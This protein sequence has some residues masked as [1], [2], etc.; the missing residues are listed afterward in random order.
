M[1]SNV[2][3]NTIDVVPAT[4]TAPARL[5]VPA[6]A[7]LQTLYEHRACPQLLRDVLGAWLSWQH[8]VDMTVG[9]VLL[10]PNLAPG[11]IAALLALDAR[12]VREQ[13]EDEKATLADFLRGRG[14]QGR[15]V[16]FLLTPLDRKDVRWAKAHVARMPGDQPMVMAAATMDMNGDVVRSARLALSGVWRENARLAEAAELL[17]GQMPD[18]EQIEAVARAVSQEVEPTGDFV[19]SATYRRAMAFI[20]TRRVLQE[21]Q[22]AGR[23]A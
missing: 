18:E 10:S 22:T 1:I 5:A 8:R 3:N 17:V 11:L 6:G 23:S 21:C 4:E 2:L 14:G 20:L 7:S 19:A 12:I 9:Q 16:R 15:K 13:G